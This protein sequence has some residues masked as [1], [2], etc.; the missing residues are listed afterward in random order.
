MSTPSSPR[1]LILL[2][3][4]DLRIHDNPLFLAA[5]KARQSHQITHL[6]PLYI[7]NPHQIEVSGF[8]PSSSPENSPYKECRSAVGSFWRCGPHRAKFIAESVWD[9][10]ETLEKLGSGLELRVGHQEKV[11]KSVIDELR[12]KGATV[13]GVWMS[14]C[15][16]TEEAAEL[17]SIQKAVQ[18]EKLEFRSFEDGSYLYDRTDLGFDPVKDLP[19]VFT[20]FRKRLEPLRETI[21]EALPPPPSLPPL[22]ETGIVEQSAP[23]AIPTC[24]PDLISA[25]QA[26]LLAAPC[27]PGSEIPYPSGIKSAHPFTG[28]ETSA[29]QRLHHLLSTNSVTTYKDTRNGL[30][31]L[32]FSTKLAAFLSQGCISARYIHSTLL[33]FENGSPQF[34]SSSSPIPHSQGFAKGESKGS[35]W[36]RFELLWRDYFA[37]CAQKYG[38]A[39]FSIYGYRHN[40]KATWNSDPNVLARFLRGATGTGIVDASQRELYHTGWTS[41]RA[42]QNVASYLAKRLHLDWRLGAEWYEYLLIDYDPA[43]NW[44]NWQYTAGVGNDPRGEERVFNQ[45]KQMRDYDFKGEYVRAWVPELRGIEGEKVAGTWLLSE[46]EKEK[47]LKELADEDKDMAMSPLVKVEGGLGGGGR[48]GKGGRGGGKGRRGGRGGGKFG[49]GEGRKGVNSEYAG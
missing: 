1:V 31:G 4:R 45:V 30:L 18:Q 7:F 9:L 39:L 49:R 25:L 37:L 46:R 22:P 15:V 26:P 35:G 33:A 29:Q 42:R 34:P 8:I 21:P 28:G 24:L 47:V 43:S 40:T 17:K 2:I 14:K 38:S 10:K 12:G 19:D 36:L 48:G 44:G 3:R 41:N 5:H 11:V 23:F 6:L 16:G 27:F 20:T 32:D 13:V